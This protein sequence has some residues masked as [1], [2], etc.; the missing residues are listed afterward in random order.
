MR[1]AVEL[2]AGDRQALLVTERRAARPGILTRADLLEALAAMSDFAHRASS[3]RA[4]SPTRRTARSSRRS[5]RPRPSRS[6]AVGEFV[7][8]YDYA[9]SANPTRAALERALGELEGGH[10]VGVLLGH[11]RRRTR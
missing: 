8:D 3:T 10:G 7:E 9:R 6:R 4:S 11:G 1:E 5:T 2:L